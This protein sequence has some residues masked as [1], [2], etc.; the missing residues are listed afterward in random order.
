[1]GLVGALIGGF[2]VGFLAS[3]DAGFWGSILVAFIGACPLIVIAR[4]VALKRTRL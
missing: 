1:M 3:G 4:F 2:L